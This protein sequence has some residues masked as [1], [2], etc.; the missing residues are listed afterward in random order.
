MNRTM[1]IVGHLKR[2]GNMEAV[3]AG[4]A[5]LILNDPVNSHS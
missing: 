2:S 3:V 4:D 5:G 1:L